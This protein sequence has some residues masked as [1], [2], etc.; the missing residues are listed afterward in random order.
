MNWSNS[1]KSA[2]SKTKIGKAQMFAFLHNWHCGFALYSCQ[3]SMMDQSLWVVSIVVILYWAFLDKYRRVWKGIS[4]FKQI[5]KSRVFFQFQSS[6]IEYTKVDDSRVFPSRWIVQE[7]GRTEDVTEK[8]KTP[9]INTDWNNLFFWS[10]QLFW[11][12][13]R[14]KSQ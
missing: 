6:A 3:H 10:N 14:L 12:F 2:R 11:Y 4:N 8:T 7:G 9:V 1:S 13:N 5:W